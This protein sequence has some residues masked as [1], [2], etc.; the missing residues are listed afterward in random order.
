MKAAAFDYRRV[1][2][3]RDAAALLA[4]AEGNSRVLAGGQS[5]GPM[6]NLRLARPRMLI[7]IKRASDFRSLASDEGVISIGAGWTH[8]EIEDGAIPETTGALMRLVARGIAYRAVRNR[9]TLGGSLAH[10][11]PAA[12]WIALMAGLGASIIAVGADGKFARFPA[13]SF[14]EGAYQ[15]KLNES[16][17]LIAV[18]V[19]R[20]SAR[21]S[22]GY[23]KIARKVGEF[24]SAI[25]VAIF[26]PQRSI[27]RVLA[28]AADGS[29]I[30]LTQTGTRLC[31][32][33]AQA[34]ITAV[35]DE[36]DVAMAEKDEARRALYATAVIR[37]LQQLNVPRENV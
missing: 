1:E 5:L 33:D 15:T 8:A 2:T 30:L 25:G 19:P 36:I 35:R 21:A 22:W 27:A 12:D 16:Q 13:D 28:G 18:E 11:D 26:D 37:A 23:C 7:D 32:G 34:A 17:V 20:L 29:P 3:L 14:V 24:A 4:E 9:G 6:L 31:E 10:A